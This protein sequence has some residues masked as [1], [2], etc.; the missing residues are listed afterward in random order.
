MA[1]LTVEN[2]RRRF[3]GIVALDGVSFD[4][5]EGEIVGLIGPNGAGK[6][7]VFNVVTRLYRPD[8]GQVTFD[9]DDLL[10]SRPHRVDSKIP[11]SPLDLWPKQLAAFS[12]YY[13]KSPLAG[14]AD[15]KVGDARH[16]QLPEQ[17]VHAIITSPPYLNAIDYIRTSKFSLIFLGS[18]L[19]ELRKIRAGAVGTEVGLGPG[20]LP[21]SLETAL[22]TRVADPRRRP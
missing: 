1:L 7:T 10:R 11:K 9:G 20:Q 5:N 15:I 18:R 13:E 4:A 6:T 16:L 3:G 8:S 19:D 22:A 21:E 12:S 2:V 14:S 17:S